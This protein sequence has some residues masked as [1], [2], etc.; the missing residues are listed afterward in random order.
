MVM[1]FGDLKTLLQPVIQKLDHS[2]V[3]NFIQNPT[4]ENIAVFVL[5]YLWKV[6]K[7]KKLSPEVGPCWVRVWETENSYAQIGMDMC[8][9][10]EL[11]RD[12]REKP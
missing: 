9:L 1:D 3:N 8:N 2:I 6:E 12:R 11:E 5:N 7:E 10:V 4:A